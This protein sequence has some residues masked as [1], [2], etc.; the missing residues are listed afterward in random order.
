M[1]NVTFKSCGNGKVVTGWDTAIEGRDWTVAV[2]DDGE[3]L[4]IHEDPDES[5]TT[6]ITIVD[7]RYPNDDPCQEKEDPDQ[8]L[9][10]GRRFPIPPKRIGTPR[11]E[12]QGVWKPG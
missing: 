4:V 12:P 7:P 9:R 6:T 10:S 3:V 8:E 11:Y 5:T 1:Q 2:T